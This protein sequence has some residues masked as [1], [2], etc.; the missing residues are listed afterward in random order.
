MSVHCLLIPHCPIS[1]MDDGRSFLEMVVPS[2]RE[3]LLHSP[4][5]R[6]AISQLKDYDLILGT[7]FNYFPPPGRAILLHST[8]EGLV[9]SKGSRQ[10]HS[11]LSR[12]IPPY[13][14]PCRY[15]YS[16]RPVPHLLVGASALPAVS[17]R[18]YPV[19]DRGRWLHLGG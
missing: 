10:S 16:Q 3:S 13:P 6:R 18:S 17:S 15:T 7:S 2:S 14:C 1:K 9:V 5:L 4:S 8:R 19:G 11:I 12:T